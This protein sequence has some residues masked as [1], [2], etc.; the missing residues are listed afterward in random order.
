MIKVLKDT[1]LSE[2][3]L[4]RY[5]KP[6]K[7]NDRE[8]VKKFCL[9]LGLLQPGDSRDV[10]VDILHVLLK[11]KQDKKTLSS[12]DLT[13][14]VH[15]E[16]KKAKVPLTGIA[17][18]NIRRQLRRLRE[19]FIVEK[20]KNAYRITEFD[21]VKNNIQEKTE[22]F[23]LLSIVERVKEYANAVDERFK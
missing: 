9:S 23:L 7:L 4:R 1:P 15:E 12:E 6:S 13:Q 14:K 17:N 11:A 18:S 8:L 19:L 22:K 5:E 20:V 10:V 16:R 3:T 2:L 21:G